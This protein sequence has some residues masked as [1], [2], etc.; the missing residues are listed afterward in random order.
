MMQQHQQ[1]PAAAPAT[2]V[3]PAPRYVMIPRLKLAAADAV[4]PQKPMAIVSANIVDSSSHS[5]S[6][7]SACDSEPSGD[8]QDPIGEFLQV[9][10][11]GKKRRLDH[12]SNEEKFQRK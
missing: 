8:E 3:A 12:L 7:S 6:R 11:A 1:Q 4:A 5:S 9:R 2:A 10:P